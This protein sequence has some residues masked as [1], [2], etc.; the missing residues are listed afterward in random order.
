MN[1]T[2]EENNT[3]LSMANA[4]R[5][6]SADAVEKAQSGHPGMPMGIAE[7]AT[8]LFS[9]HL[10]FNPYNPEWKNRDRF[11][12]SAGHGSMLLYSLLYLT[13]YKSISIDD[14]KNF[15]QIDSICA[16]VKMNISNPL[17][18]MKLFN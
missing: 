18:N 12:L 6:L 1:F 3:Y 2:E 15:R 17:S 11:I 10:R 13:G 4:I 8:I 7:V 9:K 14:I 16:G 5:F